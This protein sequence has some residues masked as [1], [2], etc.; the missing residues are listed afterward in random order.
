[1]L[2]IDFSNIIKVKVA[3]IAKITLCIYLIYK[4]WQKFVVDVEE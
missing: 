3:S 4:S 1:M 2:I